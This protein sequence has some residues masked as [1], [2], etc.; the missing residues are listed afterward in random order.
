[1]RLPV[2]SGSYGSPWTVLGNAIVFLA[3]PDDHP[4]LL[5][6]RCEDAVVPDHV[7]AWGRNDCCELLHELERLEDHV[8]GAVA[9]APLEPV[10]QPPVL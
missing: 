6:A 1:M 7:N 9:P 5:R 2:R 3:W 8:G 4:A 10:E